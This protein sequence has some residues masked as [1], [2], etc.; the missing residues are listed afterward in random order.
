MPKMTLLEVVQAALA[1]MDSDEVNSISDTTESETL[2]ALAKRC[3]YMFIN[4]VHVDSSV[5]LIKLHGVS[6][7]SRPNYLMIPDGTSGIVNIEYD[8]R[9]DTD[10]PAKYMK[11]RYIEP[12]VFVNRYLSR[13]KSVDSSHEIVSDTS[14]VSLYIQNDKNPEVFTSIDDKYLIFD[15]YNKAHGATLHESRTVCLGK[16]EPEWVNE[17]TFVIPLNETLT[18]AYLAEF[19]SS[20]FQTVKQ[21]GNN[22]AEQQARRGMVAAMREHSVIG[23]PLGIDASSMNFGYSAKS[24]KSRLTHYPNNKNYL[25]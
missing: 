6:D 17:D 12:Q 24:G 10:H 18:G 4:R 2:S 8:C 7:P 1:E 3:F 22:K 23:N 21:Q 11:M 16:K 9:E 19:I 25:D 20:A 5:A 14:G 13:G 15:S